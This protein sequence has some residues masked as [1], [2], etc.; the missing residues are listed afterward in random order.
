MKALGDIKGKIPPKSLN[1]YDFGMKMYSSQ[2]ITALI[3][4][5]VYIFMP[6]SYELRDFDGK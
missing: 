2:P 3:G 6:K 4:S 1:M 5:E